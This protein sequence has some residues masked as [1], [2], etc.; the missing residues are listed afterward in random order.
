[1]QQVKTLARRLVRGFG[2]ELTRYN[3]SKPGYDPMLDIQRYL[4]ANDHPCIFDIGANQ[5]QTIGKFQSYFPNSMIHAFEPV[6][7]TFQTLQ[8]NVGGKHHVQLNNAAL[9]FAKG[10]QTFFVNSHSDMSSF[11]EQGDQTWGEVIEEILVTVDTVDSYCEQHN[12]ERIDLL[13]SDTQGFEL[14]VFKGAQNMMQNNKIGLLYF[15]VIFANIYKNAVTFDEIFAHLKSNNFRLVSFYDFHYSKQGH[16][17]WVD[18][19][20]VNPHYTFS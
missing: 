10:Q 16:A 11:L 6:P 12:L 7:K 5:G 20:F 9:G 4:L 18:V 2:Y 17:S 1:M 14:E 19:L 8:Q 15:E 13:K 3:P